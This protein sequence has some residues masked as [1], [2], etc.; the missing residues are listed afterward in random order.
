M[1]GLLHSE[2]YRNR[3]R[4]N[5]SRNLPRIPCV[6]DAVDFRAFRDAGERLGELHVGYEEVAPYPA[7]IDAEGRDLE[8][9]EDPASFFRVL[10]MKHPGSG[11]KKD[12]SAIIY[13]HN[14]TVRDIPDAAWDY[15]INGK[16]ALSWV[17]ERQ[18]V[19]TDKG[20]RHR[21]RC[22]LLCRR[23]DR[24]PPLPARPLASHHLGQSGNDEN[25][26]GPS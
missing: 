13:N 19:K 25:R 10:K 18:T 7:V 6:K 9:V 16:P 14:I 22:Q 17:M 12:R 23:D 8:S 4:V 2:D 3:F 5:L 24:Q 11:R 1:Y 15:V 20:K 21:Q 26:A